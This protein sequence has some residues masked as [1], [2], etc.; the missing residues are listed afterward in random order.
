MFSA[1]RILAN[2]IID[3]G[4]AIHQQP[5][6]PMRMKVRQCFSDFGMFGENM[7]EICRD[8]HILR[9]SIVF[10]SFLF[11]IV[12]W[13]HFFIHVYYLVHHVVMFASNRVFCHWTV[14]FNNN[15]GVDRVEH[16]LD[17]GMV[18]GNANRVLLELPRGLL[19]TLGCP[20]RFA[21]LSIVLIQP[22]KNWNP[23]I[24]F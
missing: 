22:I 17:T 12:L 21:N 6:E 10:S 1:T 13:I 15:Y 9:Q 11:I 14:V 16:S 4:I 23:C 24:M 5:M 8:S 20:F 7:R 3:D 19:G 2:N 18:S